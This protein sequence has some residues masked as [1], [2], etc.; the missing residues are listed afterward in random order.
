M[1]QST[2]RAQSCLA[3]KRKGLTGMKFSGQMIV[4]SDM[5]KSKQF[6]MEYLGEKIGLDLTNYVVFQNSF[7]MMTRPQWQNVTGEGGAPAGGAHGFELYYEEDEIEAFA[8]KMQATGSVHVF[9]P[10]EEAPWGQ[11]TFRFLDPDGHVVEVGE[12]MQAVVR[13]FLLSGMTAEQA[14]ERTMMP[15]PFVRRVQKTL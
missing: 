15:L 12:T 11:R 14:A 9:T 10:L 13:R 8:Q 1:I 6:Y 2:R 5:E 7:S 3:A 4:V